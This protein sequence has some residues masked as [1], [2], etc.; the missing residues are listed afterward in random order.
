M[1]MLET[2]EDIAGLQ[3]VLDARVPGV[4]ATDDLF[5]VMCVD[6]HLSPVL[7][8][9]VRFETAPAPPVP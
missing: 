4:K 8:R 3:Q 5:K 6:G 7:A 9:V 2:A 1:K